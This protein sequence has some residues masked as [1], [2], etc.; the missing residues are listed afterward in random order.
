M[1]VDKCGA[2]VRRDVD[3]ESAVEEDWVRVRVRVRVSVTI[4]TRIV[5]DLEPTHHV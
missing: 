1:P 2:V 4:D 5:R 3:E